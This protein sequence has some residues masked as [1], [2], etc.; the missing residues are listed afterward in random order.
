MKLSN[1]SSHI[2][3]GLVLGAMFGMLIGFT[4]AFELA[5]F[6]C[7]VFGLITIGFETAQKMQST[8]PNYIAKKWL[9]SLI[10]I[11]VANIAFNAMF[12]AIMWRAGYFV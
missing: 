11:V 8:D 1:T 5:I 4:Q 6:S 9:D 2:I 10:D 12:W 7:I 3:I